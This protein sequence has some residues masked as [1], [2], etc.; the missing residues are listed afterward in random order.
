[1]DAPAHGYRAAFPRRRPERFEVEGVSF[2]SDHSVSDDRTSMTV[3]DWARSITPISPRDR[4]RQ[5]GFPL[6]RKLT[7]AGHEIGAAE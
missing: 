2:L 3:A 6:S 4:S 7:A 1:M 5:T